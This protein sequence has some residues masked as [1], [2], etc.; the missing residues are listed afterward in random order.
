MHPPV[1]TAAGDRKPFEPPCGNPKGLCF[2]HR[3]TRSWRPRRSAW[4]AERGIEV[5][6]PTMPASLTPHDFVA[7]WRNASAKERS[8]YQ[9]HF[10]DLCRLV[11]HETP[12]E[13]DASGR[14]FAFEAGAT[15][16]GGE[17][18]WADVFK[19]RFFAFEYKGKHADL[20]K[21]YRQLQ[22]YR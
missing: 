17:Q 5:Q 19:P 14:T 4:G 18:G 13:F 10:I 8:A 15:K 2:C 20:D 7:K 3:P 21:A 22:L 9:E 16:P 11:G 6:F 12:M 1:I